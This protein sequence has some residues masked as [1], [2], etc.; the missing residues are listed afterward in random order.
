MIQ[1]IYVIKRFDITAALTLIVIT[2]SIRY[3]FSY[4]GAI[5]LEQ[6]ARV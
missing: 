5:H 6:T 2:A 1:P 3:I 4:I